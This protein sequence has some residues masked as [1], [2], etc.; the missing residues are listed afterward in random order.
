MRE[1]TELSEENGSP[2]PLSYARDPVSKSGIAI[3]LRGRLA[4]IYY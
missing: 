4:R 3:L 2:R 1:R